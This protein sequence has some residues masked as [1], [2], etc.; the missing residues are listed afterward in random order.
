MKRTLPHRVRDPLTR[1]LRRID[2]EKRL[3]VYRVWSFW[4]EEVGPDIAAHAHPLSVR[5]AVLAVAVN[6][7]AWMQELQFLKGTLKE[8][9]NARLGA[10]LIDDIYL[11]HG[12]IPRPARPRAALPVAAE[13]ATAPAP[14]PPLRDSQLAAIFDRLARA[15]ADRA[16]R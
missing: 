14:I 10:P 3:R 16:R 15:H 8:R 13:G 9:L 6:N 7:H 1:V 2:P 12:E 4:E 11:V 5:G